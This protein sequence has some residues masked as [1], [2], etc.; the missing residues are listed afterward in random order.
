VTFPEVLLQSG[1]PPSERQQF[2]E[3]HMPSFNDVVAVLRARWKLRRAQLGGPR[4]RLWG[5]AQILPL[6]HLIVGDRVRLVSK[7]ACLEIFVAQGATLS[8]GASSFIN[9]G[10]SIAALMR[11]E[12]GEG[13]TIGPHCMILDNDFHRLEPDRRQELPPSRPVVLGRN[14]WLGARVMVLPG[15]TI[16]DDTVVAAGSVVTRDLPSGILA[17]GIP[18]RQIRVLP[19]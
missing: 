11:V 14:V 5:A 12:I 8:I 1:R 17:G 4:V 13:A 16:G 15:V 9:H 10:T 6:G 19:R 3:E 2:T 18:A 7:P